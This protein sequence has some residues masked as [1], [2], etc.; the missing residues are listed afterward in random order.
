MYTAV[1]LRTRYNEQGEA[2]IWKEV[3][4]DT[5][6]SFNTLKNRHYKKYGINY[7]SFY[8]IDHNGE[9]IYSHVGY[10]KNWG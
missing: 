7:E 1:T 9:T 5:D 8:I 2:L 3:Y 6:I 10:Q 4:I